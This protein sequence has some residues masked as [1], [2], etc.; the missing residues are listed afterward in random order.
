MKKILVAVVLLF[1]LSIQ[2]VYALQ[3]AI[4][5]GVRDGLAIGLMA[6]DQAGRNFGLRIG[7]E[8]NTG[9]QPV[10]FF[11]GGKFYLTSLGRGI[12]LSLGLGLVSYFGRHNA[13]LGF[14]VSFIFNNLFHRLP[15]FFEVGVDVVDTGRL[16][17]QF[18]YKLY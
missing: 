3:P 4:I 15:L 17:A 18:G 14:S 8:A 13:D 1:G 9:Y 11:F 2:S 6:D 12:P 7:L 10:I 5:G 16:Q